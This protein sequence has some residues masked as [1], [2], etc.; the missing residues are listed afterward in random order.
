MTKTVLLTSILLFLTATCEQKGANEKSL[1][2]L[3]K[4]L[5]SAEAQGLSGSV[6]LMDKDSMIYYRGLGF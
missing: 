2:K 5:S 3:D 4:L 6:L 1:E